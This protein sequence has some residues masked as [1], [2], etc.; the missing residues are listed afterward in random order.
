MNISSISDFRRAM[1]NGPYAWPGGY[2]CYF[3]CADGEALSFAAARENRREILHALLDQARNDW[4]VVAFEINWE[5]T[6][7]TCAH[8]N[9][10]IECAFGP[11]LDEEKVA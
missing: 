1:R 2:P 11:D 10:P 3:L 7:L 4:K 9:E 5:D 6:D 8:S